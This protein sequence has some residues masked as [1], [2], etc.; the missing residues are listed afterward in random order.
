M[1]GLPA[2]EDAKDIKNQPFVNPLAETV[3]ILPFVIAS[4][5]KG[6]KQSSDC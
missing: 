6:A 2:M 3:E 4:D 1:L 5:R